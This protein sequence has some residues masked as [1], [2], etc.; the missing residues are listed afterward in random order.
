MTRTQSFF[1]FV[2]FHV[3]FSSVALAH[4]SSRTLLNEP[5]KTSGQ[6]V[7]IFDFDLTL[8]VQNETGWDTGS[9]DS[10]GI[11]RKCKEYGY[12]IAL[13]SANCNTEKMKLILPNHIDSEIFNAQWF[14]S[15]AFQNCDA[16]KTNEL[17]KILKYFDTSPKCAMFFD[18]LEFN[19][20]KY[21]RDVGVHWRHV[22]PETGVTWDD[23]WGLVPE[24]QSTCDCHPP[25]IE[26]LSES[27]KL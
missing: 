8:R 27:N 17:S 18:D 19:L 1:V 20:R 25:K 7:C 5:S 6:C 3:C 12:E 4:S 9:K 2:L 13:A 26:P 23:F 24:L 22:N 11:V 16:Y 10:R 14:E 21:A 15:P